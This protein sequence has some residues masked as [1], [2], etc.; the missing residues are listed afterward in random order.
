MKAKLL[1]SSAHTPG[2]YQAVLACT[3]GLLVTAVA[4]L[5]GPSLVWATRHGLGM[6]EHSKSMTYGIISRAL[7]LKRMHMAI[8]L[9][10]ADH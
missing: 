4:L 6:A 1:R 5:C 9:F 8:P 3:R 10:I 2:S 7:A